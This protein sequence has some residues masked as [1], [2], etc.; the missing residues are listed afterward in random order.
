MKLEHITDR[1]KIFSI[2]Q[3]ERFFFPLIGA[4]IEGKQKGNVYFDNI[5]EIGWIIVIHKFGFAQI[6]LKKYTEQTMED[7]CKLFISDIIIDDHKLNKIRIYTIDDILLEYIKNNKILKFEIGTRVRFCLPK[8]I[9]K[10]IG[11]EDQKINDNEFNY[12]DKHFKLDLTTRFWRNKIQF[13]EESTPFILK[14]NQKITSI[15]YGAAVSN[16][17]SEIDVY[18]DPEYRGKG[19]AK[20]AVEG[21]IKKCNF[22]HIKPLWDCYENNE[23]SIKTALAVGFQESFRYNFLIITK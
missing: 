12:V 18:T 11:V 1:R 9:A 10:K 13:I 21:F 3:K 20:K 2:Y 16:N 15:C 8:L 7:I 19:Y 23:G 17:F 22:H 6:I 14:E 4:V 5:N